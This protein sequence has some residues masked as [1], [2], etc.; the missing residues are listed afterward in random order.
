MADW[1]E[2][3]TSGASSNA[4]QDIQSAASVDGQILIWNNSLSKY[5]PALITPGPNLQIT[6]TPGSIK[7]SATDTNTDVNVSESNLN[8]KLGQLSSNVTIGQADTT[9]T[10]ANDLVVTGDLTVSGDSSI[11]NVSNIEVEGKMLELGVSD[12]AS[13]STADGC[14]ILIDTGLE[15]EPSSPTLKWNNNGQLTGWTISGHNTS[16]SYAIMAF[17]TFQGFGQ[18]PT[19]D[20]AGI[21]SF[22]L[23]TDDDTLYIRLS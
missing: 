15:F 8:F 22:A 20:S 13:T 14:G 6:N 3:L 10:V 4:L 12:D 16:T 5:Q 18:A 11:I 1:K 19:G 21:G 2:V 7:L 23:N 17:E 9:V